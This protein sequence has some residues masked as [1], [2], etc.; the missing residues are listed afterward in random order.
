MWVDS[1]DVVDPRH[2]SLLWLDPPTRAA[3]GHGKLSDRIPCYV[4]R[5]LYD[6]QGWQS[7][8]NSATTKPPGAR[9]GKHDS[10]SRRSLK[11]SYCD[12]DTH[13]IESCYYLN[14]FLVDH[15]LHG[16]NIKAKNKWLVAYTAE[17]D[18]IPEHD[19]KSNESPTFTT[20]EYNQLIALLHNRPCNFP[21][22][23]AT[24]IIT[25]I[26][27]LSQHN[28]HSN[29]Y[30]TMDSGASNHISCF[31]PTHNTI[32]TQHDFVGLPHGGKTTIKN[33]GSIKL[34]EALT[35]DGVLHVP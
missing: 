33:I 13:I 5:S 19:S 29:I 23:N 8:S 14:D 11:C 10:N 34:Y 16:K 20:E 35:L 18:P 12:E 6:H 17:K 31:A 24:S 25:S 7:S 15:K 4:N 9:D 30:W 21:L 32:N 1:D 3:N 27:N 2:T 28:P 26:C 22:V